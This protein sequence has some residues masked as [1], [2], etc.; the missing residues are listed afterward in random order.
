MA[1]HE[2][3]EGGTVEKHE[4]DEKDAR[5]LLHEL[6]ELGEEATEKETVNRE[7]QPAGE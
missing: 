7:E 2:G 4:V 1:A 6:K 3:A 5:F